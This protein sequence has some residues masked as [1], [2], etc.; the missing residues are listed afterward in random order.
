[1][2]SLYDDE[3][4]GSLEM[5]RRIFMTPSARDRRRRT[6][7][8]CTRDIPRVSLCDGTNSSFL[9]GRIVKGRFFSSARIWRSRTCTGSRTIF[10]IGDTKAVRRLPKSWI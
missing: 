3:S 1:M 7:D 6:L 9:G 8:A 10:D 5:N 4:R 2:H